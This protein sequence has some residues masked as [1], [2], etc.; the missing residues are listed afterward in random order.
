[1]AISWSTYHL[2]LHQRLLR[3]P[4]LLPPGAQLLLAVSGGQDSMALTALMLDLQRLHHWQLQLWHGNHCWRQESEQQAAA[5]AAWAKSKNLKI[6]IDSW[7]NPLHTE[8]AAREWRYSCLE[9]QAKTEGCQIVLTAHTAN[10]RSETL[11]LHLARGSHRR[12]LGSLMAQRQLC[13]GIQLVRPLLNFSR[14]DTA[15]IC[16]TLAIPI[17][18]D[19]SNTDQRFSRNRIRNE[20]LPVLEQ[21]HPG[22]TQRMAATAEGFSAEQENYGELLDLALKA[23]QADDSKIQRK[24]LMAL[25]IPCRGQLLQHWLLQQGLAAMGASQIKQLWPQLESSRGPNQMVLAKGK[26][27]EWDRLHIWLNS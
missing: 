15:R 9:Q 23:L 11:L 20:V 16:E 6:Q 13:P 1:M 8:A 7:A 5:L 25:S 10:D 18:L 12:G 24:K 22:A 21:L 3:E 26:T 27:L 14:A 4:L 2:R 19:P 17:W